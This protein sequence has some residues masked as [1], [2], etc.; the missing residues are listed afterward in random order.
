MLAPFYFLT[1]HP[2]KN[3]GN[4]PHVQS[5]S[6]GAALRPSMSYAVCGSV[7]GLV[8]TVLYF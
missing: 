7:S 6:D 5:S 2:L 3:T 1:L 4:H 8:N